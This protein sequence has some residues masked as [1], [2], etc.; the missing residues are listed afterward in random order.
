MSW[1]VTNEVK[2]GDELRLGRGQTI[3]AGLEC[4]FLHERDCILIILESSIFM[5]TLAQGKCQTC[6]GLRR[7]VARHKAHPSPSSYLQLTAGIEKSDFWVSLGIS[8]TFQE[9]PHAQ[10]WLASTGWTLWLFCRLLILLFCFDFFFLLF[11]SQREKWDS[12][13]YHFSIPNT[14]ILFAKYRDW[15]IF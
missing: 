15:I 4:Q 6:A 3:L 11:Y 5:A 7:G 14:N 10:E 12:N 8:T 1:S 9:R 13:R 2:G